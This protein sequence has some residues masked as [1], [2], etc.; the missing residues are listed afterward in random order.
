M[1]FVS[2]ILVL[3]QQVLSQ[4]SLAAQLRRGL[5]RIGR[6]RAACALL[7]IFIVTCAAGSDDGK[8]KSSVEGASAAIENTGTPVEVDGRPILLVY[9][10][11]GGFTPQ[12]RAEAI[13]QRIIS[14]G[15]NRIIQVE[16]IHAEDRGTWTEILAGK[17]RIMGITQA[18][19]M[20]AERA[21]ADLAA[22][23]AEIIR[24]VVVQY[25]VDHTLRHLIWGTMYAILA[26]AACLALIVGLFWFR[27]RFRK[28]LEARLIQGGPAQIKGVRIGH[29]LGPPLL[30]I[31]HAAFWIVLLA[32]LQAYGTVVLRFFPSTKYTSSQVTNW[33]FSE[34]AAL[35]K[36]VIAY[37]PNLI[38]LA[39]VCL[40]TSYLMKVNQYFFGELRDGKISIRGFYPD[41]AEPTA[42]LVRTLILVASVIIA[43][44]YLPGSQS[45]AFKSISVFIGV[46]LSLGSTS[47]VAHGVAGTILTYMRAF[48]VGDFV[49]IGSDVGEVIEKTLL[50]TRIC[51]Q[52]NEV[53]TI[54]NGTVLG[55]VVVNYSA[56]A[57]KLGVIFHTV[58]TIGYSAPW[59]QV[60]DL[61]IS[62]AL[63]TRDVLHDPPPFVLQ[64]ALNDFYVSYE[65]NAYTAKPR[66]MLNIYSD[67]HQNIQDKF[68][69]AG[70]EINSPHYA[71]LRDGNE[72]TIPQSYLSREYRRPAFEVR[73]V[74]R[75]STPVSSDA[76]GKK[77]DSAV[78]DY[79]A[80]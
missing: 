24:Q 36:N 71:S 30:M 56:E 6:A 72:T 8:E 20:G 67:L 21:R 68:N 5:R 47:A 18:D 57:R 16:S 40:I 29:Y 26:T 55:G 23:Y 58:A 79:E 69:E 35:G 62:A 7:S 33:L 54:P 74:D 38:L 3:S 12:E 41:W 11:I 15:K 75:S 9:A 53:V 31:I 34:L 80:V 45:P 17:D 70:V 77:V 27:K 59:R 43:F 46:L 4:E 73:Q 19:A 66:N 32:M 51:T 50:V 2:R 52:K 13:G 39:F 44:P 64:T 42:N 61:L 63:A 76:E 1:T 22:E 65:L 14:L 60:H 28:R 49:R 25:R 10:P 37:T 78:Q 48:Q